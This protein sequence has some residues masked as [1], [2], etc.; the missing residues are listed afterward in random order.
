MNHRGVSVAHLLCALVVLSSLGLPL[1]VSAQTPITIIQGTASD[2][3]SGAAIVGALLRWKDSTRTVTGTTNSSGAY[4]FSVPLVR[5]GQCEKVTILATGNLY[6]SSKKALK[7]CAGTTTAVN[8]LLT[9]LP[10]KQIGTVNGQVVGKL[11]GKLGIPNATVSIYNLSLPMAGLTATTDENGFY[12]IPGVGFATG[13]TIEASTLTPPCIATISRKFS[14]GAAQVTENFSGKAFQDGALVCPPNTW[15][16]DAD[17]S[18][19]PGRLAAR[20]ALPSHAPLLLSAETSA[21]PSLGVDPTIQWQL[22]SADG[23]LMNSGADSWNS[24]HVNDIVKVGPSEIVVGANMSG[25]WDV[26]WSSNS[27]AAAPLSFYWPS[28]GVNSL[29]PG[30]DGNQHLYA[31]TGDR[32]GAIPSGFLFETDTSAIAPLTNWVEDTKPKCDQIYKILTLPSARIIVLACDSG[33]WWSPIPPPPAAHGTYTWKLAVG[34]KG[35]PQSVVSGSFKGLAA[36]PSVAGT[37]QA[38]V[39]AAAAGATLANGKPHNLLLY[40]SWANGNLVLNATTVSSYSGTQP[41]RTSVASCDADPHQLYAVTNNVG[42][43]NDGFIGAVWK[44]EDGGMTWSGVNIPA[45]SGNQGDYN[46]AIAVNPSNCSNFAIAWRDRVSVSYD[47]GTS[48]VAL[49]STCGGDST[50]QGNLHG[51]YHAVMFDPDDVQTLWVGEDGGVASASPVFMGSTPTFNSIYNQHLSDLEVFTA[52]ASAVAGTPNGSQP[53]GLVA[54][55]LQDNGALYNDLGGTGWWNQMADSDGI[56]VG[57][58]GAGPPTVFGSPGDTLVFSDSSDTQIWTS[59]TWDG[60]AMYLHGGVPPSVN[61]GGPG[62]LAEVRSPKFTNGKG[63]LMYEIGSGLAN[64][65]VVFGLFSDSTG[66]DLHWEQIGDVG[67]G[68]NVNALSSTDGNTVFA[69]TG[70]GKIFTFTPQAGI[71]VQWP[72]NSPAQG[73]V[74]AIAEIFP[75]I[76]FAALNNGSGSGFVAYFDGTSWSAVG[77]G[78]PTSRPFLGVAAPNLGAVFAADSQTVYVSHDLGS[79]WLVASIGLPVLDMALA[80]PGGTHTLRWAV[81]SDGLIHL[82]LASRG[83]SVFQAVLPVGQ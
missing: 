15:G 66:G 64:R 59:A 80:G 44:S 27:S 40:G 1:T 25:A 17:G 35:V 12:S 79:T 36:G 30:V 14:M 2:Q 57:F 34:G 47:A 45:N 20:K 76:A 62:V 81:Q 46:Q 73:S 48:Y 18:G 33:I 60:T 56:S 13:L 54:A 21:Q 9:P 42:N 65:S 78:L 31:G 72:V 41:G 3:T 32:Y 4:A 49:D 19:G 29:V 10:A 43:P 82:Y 53:W 22:A 74:Q 7:I 67:A 37:G 8:F 11:F 23:I 58:S 52:T 69:G 6:E 61:A 77:G 5:S 68:L 63:E 71:P 75:T 50:C 16:P 83:W 38:S 51:D 55:V 70:E 26:A 24:G 28:L 39:V